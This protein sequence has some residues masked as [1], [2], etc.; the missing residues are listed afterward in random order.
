MLLVFSGQN[1]SPVEAGAHTFIGSCESIEEARLGAAEWARLQ[2]LE[3]FNLLA[4]K[5]PREQAA[6]M[7]QGATF[8]HQIVDF[9]AHGGAMKVIEET[10][11]DWQPSH[12][13]HELHAA[14]EA[15]DA[16]ARQEAQ[17]QDGDVGA[18]EAEGIEADKWIA[19]WQ[20]RRE[21]KS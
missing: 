4:T 2:R 12:D 3:W 19:E 11:P 13:S 8:W 20:R 7:S 14:R 5:H 21:R 17:G 15:L 10:K 6:A 18:A 16:L 9:D 1:H